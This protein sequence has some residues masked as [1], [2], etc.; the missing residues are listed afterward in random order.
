MGSSDFQ[1]ASPKYCT[2]DHQFFYL[3]LFD[4]VDAI[5]MYRLGMHWE[6]IF[7]TEHA[8]FI[9]ALV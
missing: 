6:N 8:D 2:S 1:R 3:C 5:Y 4:K 7:G 9:T